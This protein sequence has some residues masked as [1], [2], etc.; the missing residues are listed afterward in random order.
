MNQNFQFMIFTPAND[1]F[2]AWPS[3]VAMTFNLREQMF[4][5][6]NS[7]KLF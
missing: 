7:A 2:I 1:H 5:M 4:Q 3:N 6:N